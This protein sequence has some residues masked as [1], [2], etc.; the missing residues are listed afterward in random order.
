MSRQALRL[1]VLIGLVALLGV[2]VYLQLQGEP[3]EVP[4][5][6]TAVADGGITAASAETTGVVDLHLDALKNE[7]PVPDPAARD[8]FRFRARVAPSSPVARPPAPASVAT[9]PAA[10]AGPAPPPAIRLKFIGLVEAAY[11][12]E[13]VAVLSDALGNVF[14]GREGDIIDGRYRVLKIG[15]ESAELAYVDGRGRQAMRLS[16]Q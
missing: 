3:V 16:G 10:P 2:I 11:P 8:P 12:S 1:P 6:E 9:P 13:R 7:V 15:V 4:A 5:A 14:Y